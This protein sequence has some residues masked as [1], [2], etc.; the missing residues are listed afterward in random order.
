MPLS[1]LSSSGLKDKGSVIL[2]VK[3]DKGNTHKQT[4]AKKLDQKAIVPFPQH[5][6]KSLYA[7][8]TCQDIN[9]VLIYEKTTFPFVISSSSSE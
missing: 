3:W 8:F 1:E 4:A 9:C 6:K 2:Y 7:N 5:R